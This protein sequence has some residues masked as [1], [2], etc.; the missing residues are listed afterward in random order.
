CSSKAPPGG[1][2]SCSPTGSFDCANTIN[3]IVLPMLTGAGI[4]PKLA[5][6]TELCRRLSLDL[7]GVAPTLQDYQQHCAGRTPAQ[8][9][10]DFMAQPGY[11]ALGQRVW[12][13]AL[14]YDNRQVWYSYIQDLDAQVARL[15]R[16]ELAYPDF[17]ATAVA[18]PAFVGEF[19]G[20][21]VI[22]YAF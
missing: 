8:M 19:V 10:D 5:S 3:A 16:G 6:D 1:P 15:Y 22:A 13:D 20:E 11:V 17:A 12:A 7:T 18:H 21:N 14:Q 2:G 9:V 4:Q